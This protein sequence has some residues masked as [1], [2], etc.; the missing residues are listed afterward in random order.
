MASWNLV[1]PKWIDEASRGG[2]GHLVTSWPAQLILAAAVGLGLGGAAIVVTGSNSRFAPLLLAGL[3]APFI[4]AVVG[5]VRY[6]LLILLIITIPTGPDIYLGYREAIGM[7]GGIGGWN[8]SLGTVAL[9][10]LYALWIGA[11][12]TG[13]AYAPRPALREAR[14]VFLYLLLNIVSILFARDVFASLFET[15]WLI[16]IVLMFLYV[17]STV[18]TRRDVYVILA[19]MMAALAIESI[20]MIGVAATGV[21]F[22]VAG[23]ST[24]V[25]TTSVYAGGFT[26]AAGTLGSPNAAGAYLAFLLAPALSLT[27][28]HLPKRLRWL[29]GVAFALGTVALIL[30]LSRGSLL[31]F[32]IAVMVLT[33]IGLHRRWFAASTIVAMAAVGIVVAVIFG[34]TLVARLFGE[35][36]GAAEARIPLM[37]IAFLVIGDHPLGV[38]LNNF[39]A[40][41]PAY[42]G[43]QFSTQFIYSVHN[44]YLTIWAEIGPVGIV[45]FLWILAAAVRRA[46]ACAHTLGPDLAPFAVAV[47][48]SLLGESVHMFVDVYKSWAQLDSLFLVAGLLIALTRLGR[49]DVAG[50]PANRW[51]R[52]PAFIPDYRTTGV[53]G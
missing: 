38:G 8:I 19:A 41:L 40:V 46:W 22:E 45:A 6:V 13:V 35:D 18:E 34:P 11:A 30:T 4:V 14:P 1:Q 20:I 2:F 21:T 16:Q 47:F 31:S 43:P 17:A 3:L 50:R 33:A 32:G 39:T 24:R 23:I 10:G 15:F 49:A 26:R 53:G 7:L 27:I 42:V 51:V 29:G 37:Q 36:H 12:L 44:Y 52:L 28:C 25:T 9:G 48:G 5:R